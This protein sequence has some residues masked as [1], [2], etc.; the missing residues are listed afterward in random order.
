MD[1]SS[2]PHFLGLDAAGGLWDQLGGPTGSKGGPGAGEGM[3]IGDIASGIWPQAKSFSDRDANGKLVYQQ[4]SGFHG[5]CESA[6]TV[7]DGTW[8]ANLCNK[9]L[10][11]AQHFD[12]AWGG[13]SAIDAQ[14]PWIHLTARLQRAGTHTASTGRREQRR[15]ADW[16]RA[17]FGPI[18]AWR[19]GRASPR[20]R[21]VVDTGCVHR[22]RIHLGPH[23]CHRSGGRRRRRRN[24]LLDLGIAD[25]LRRPGGDLVPLRC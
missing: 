5:K 18:S 1:T 24:Q 16:P 22:Q 23:G 17:G 4:I 11:A 19:R 9:K 21:R 25:E 13:D 8:D 7:T 14:R 15:A 10:I 3:I 2:T 20:T 12:A 6:E